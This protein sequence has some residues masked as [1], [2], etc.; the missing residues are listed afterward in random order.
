MGEFEL[1]S[2]VVLTGCVGWPR[3]R[4]GISAIGDS[5]N[6]GVDSLIDRDLGVPIS[7]PDLRVVGGLVV[8]CLGNPGRS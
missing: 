1:C 8:L 3:S 7:W 6:W 4:R 2:Y 5:G